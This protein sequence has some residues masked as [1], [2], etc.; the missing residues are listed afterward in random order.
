MAS[1]WQ[2]DGI[3]TPRTGEPDPLGA[4]VTG[5]DMTVTLAPGHASLRGF[6][7][8]S[9]A[10][11]NIV[12]APNT[13]TQPRVDRITVRL[14]RT[15][16][17]IGIA[18][19]QG[20]P[21]AKPQPPALSQG[22]QGVVDVPLYRITVSPQAGAITP[23]DLEDERIYAPIPAT[24]ANAAARRAA[25]EQP[26]PGQLTYLQ[27]EDR[28]ELFTRQSW[29]PL[30]PGPWHPLPLPGDVVAHSGNPRWRLVNGV[31][32]LTGSVERKDGK[33]FNV[34]PSWRLAVLPPEA[35]PAYI[36]SFV[37]ATSR[38]EAKGSSLRVDVASRGAEN[39]GEVLADIQSPVKWIY[40]DAIRFS[41]E[42]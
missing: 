15:E 19:L 10:P 42:G 5:Q 33:D 36:R 12:V 41:V 11:R 40:L 14:N 22:Q 20:T 4:T 30:T 27:D 25:P 31:V 2:A 35:R 29:T 17:R 24:Y 21:A 6:H 34:A 32:E 37:C 7:Y 3:R 26:V 9:D 16:Q 23:G 8:Y 1:M 28:M 38:N 18:Y 13:G 39:A